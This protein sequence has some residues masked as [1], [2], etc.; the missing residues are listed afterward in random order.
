MCYIHEQM[1]KKPR[2]SRGT[3]ALKLELQAAVSH[4]TR[5]LGTKLRLFGRAGSTLILCVWALCPH[6]CLCPTCMPGACRDQKRASESLEVA[7]DSEPSVGCWE[8][9]LGPLEEQQ[10][11]SC[12]PSFQ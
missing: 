2:G 5:V 7:D 3:E 1:P 4:P 8:L 9:N 11:L 6:M 12:L 10:V